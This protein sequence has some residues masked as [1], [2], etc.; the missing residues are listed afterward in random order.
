MALRCASRRGWGGR[1]RFRGEHSGPS[2]LFTDVMFALDR[3][4]HKRRRADELAYENAISD[5]LAQLGFDVTQGK[6]LDDGREADI[7][8]RSKGN[9]GDWKWND[10]MVEMKAHMLT[11]NERDR[12]MGQIESYASTWP[13]GLILMVCGDLRGDLLVPLHEKV[14]K[15]R[16]EGRVVA[17]VVKGRDADGTLV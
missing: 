12:A 16:D 1:L 7:V 14:A 10:V 11:T 3:W 5:R 17:L 9:V 6:R 8:V 4:E 15:L 2:P 13:G